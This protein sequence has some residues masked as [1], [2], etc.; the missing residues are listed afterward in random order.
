MI[1]VL[2]LNAPPILLAAL[3]GGFSWAAAVVAAIAVAAVVAVVA[4]PLV[5]A[6]GMT[7]VA[8]GFMAA[9]LGVA[10]GAVAGFWYGQSGPGSDGTASPPPVQIAERLPGPAPQPATKIEVS[11]PPSAESPDQARPFSCRIT[12]TRGNGDSPTTT[13]EE[14]AAADAANLRQAFEKKLAEIIPKSRPD[15]NFEARIYKRPF[16]GKPTIDG[17]SQIMEAKGLKPDR[18]ESPPPP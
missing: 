2:D 15:P 8:A 3:G 12:V 5:L 18:Y 4:A 7:I 17:F 13:T 1:H 9:A 16:P 11:F 14:I 6:G 10:G